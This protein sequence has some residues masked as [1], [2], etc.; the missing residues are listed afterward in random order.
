[1]SAYVYLCTKLIQRKM[2]HQRSRL[3]SAVSQRIA[4]A[5]VAILLM[6]GVLTG[7]SGED[8]EKAPEG[9]AM[10][11]WRTTLRLDSAERNF[12]TDNSITR[13]Y[14]RFFDVVN[15]AERGPVPNAT[16][17][18]PEDT[19]QTLIPKGI[20]CI[21]VVFVLPECL[22]GKTA[23]EELA[24]LIVKRV[25]DMCQTHDLPAPR[26][27]QI[28]CDWTMST[29]DR[30]YKLM[31]AVT[32]EAHSRN[33]ATSVTVRLHQLSDEPPVADYGTLMVYNTGSLS[34]PDKGNPILSASAIE[35]FL[36]FVGRYK[37][38]LVAAYPVF[39]WNV[40]YSAPSTAENNANGASQFMGILY[41]CKPED[42][43]EIFRKTGPDEWT[44][45][46]SERFTTALGN[47]ESVLRVVPGMVLRRFTSP[48]LP[49][50]LKI[51][52]ALAA[53]QPNINQCVILYD[54]NSQNLET[55]KGH[56]EELF[57]N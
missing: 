53:E 52:K 18:F 9:R 37:L 49:E 48:P 56:Y 36:K 32:S 23:P 54:L 50:L 40:L 5:A 13:L 27:V 31:E 12:L 10:Y 17:M 2:K 55:Y 46:A 28:D 51:K 3:Y 29:R 33:M 6:A 8:Y 7:C 15:D 39:S 43:P 30:F 1:M 34:S 22:K 45:V 57:A 14:L 20:E 35:P 42:A 24:A 21:P 47:E 25:A 11:F 19:D 4:M 41:G 16:L 38:P 26:E 44:A